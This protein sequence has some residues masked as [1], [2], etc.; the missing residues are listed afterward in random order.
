VR[1]GRSYGPGP[2]AVAALAL[3][4][5]AGWSLG[6]APGTANSTEPPRDEAAA[7][8]PP[9]KVIRIYAENWKWTP[10]VIRVARGTR[11]VLKF[12]SHDAP[13][14]FELKGY[15]IKVPL[16][17]DSKAETS[18]VVDRPGTFRWRC[19]R[20]CGDGCPKMTG[21]LIVE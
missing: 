12:E 6:A 10:N 2:K 8:E 3:V 20:P 16:P 11:L 17:Q 4:F 5:G 14:S 15:A 13:H 9:T 1:T 21:H 18:F 19:G 7:V